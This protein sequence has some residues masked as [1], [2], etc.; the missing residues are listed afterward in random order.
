MVKRRPIETVRW[1]GDPEA[2]ARGRP[3]GAQG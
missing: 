2:A 3:R 1:D